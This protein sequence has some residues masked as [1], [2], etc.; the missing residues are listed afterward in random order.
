[1][2]G[3]T[4][5]AEGTG[6][7][8][9]VDSGVVG[10][11][12]L[13][14]AADHTAV[15]TAASGGRDAA[16]KGSWVD[17]L[18]EIIKT[19][20]STVRLDERPRAERRKAARGGLS[21]TATY[22]EGL[23]T[24]ENSS[25]ARAEL[26]RAQAVFTAVRLAVDDAG[27]AELVRALA[28]TLRVRRSSVLFPGADDLV[29]KLVPRVRSGIT[30]AQSAR[31][32]IAGVGTALD[33]EAK[34][35]YGIRKTGGYILPLVKYAL[36]ELVENVKSMDLKLLLAS[37]STVQAFVRG[38]SDT[39]SG[40]K[41]RRALARDLS[42][43]LRGGEV[44]LRLLTHCLG[45]VSSSV[46]DRSSLGT[47]IEVMVVADRWLAGVLDV[48]AAENEWMVAL[49]SVFAQ[50]PL[51]TAT[52]APLM[53]RELMSRRVDA[54]S[55]A[56]LR[57]VSWALV[58]L[59]LAA[60]DTMY[61]LAVRICRMLHL[62]C[63]RARPTRARRRRRRRACLMCMRCLAACRGKTNPIDA[64]GARMDVLE[65]DEQGCDEPR[66]ARDWEARG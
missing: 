19:T 44:E 55:L 8:I 22:A 57:K 6:P 59:R 20:T 10:G 26:A 63:A 33:E 58:R 1:L 46:K 34:R 14:A 37:L 62:V 39:S 23:A 31:V 43:R 18:Q 52:T 64:G 4:A 50:L 66:D 49:L 48:S 45:C 53:A 60:D 51:H 30:D 65:H 56:E 5:E 21:P 24:I 61:D 3:V 29:A 12:G 9:G 7:P 32:V 36:Q 15:V 11:C 41:A 42:R 27:H 16:R 25:V 35:T 13:L 54:L 17:N 28:A 40:I 38:A 47:T 2:V